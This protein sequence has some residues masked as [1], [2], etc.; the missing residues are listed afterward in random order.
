MENVPQQSPQR[1]LDDGGHILCQKCRQAFRPDMLAQFF[2][3]KCIKPR[4]WRR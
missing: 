2:C 4:R 3:R 1:H